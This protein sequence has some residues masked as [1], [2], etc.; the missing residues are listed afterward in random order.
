[1]RRAFLDYRFMLSVALAALVSGMGLSVWPLPIDHPIL[2]LIALNRPAI[3]QGVSYTYAAMWF[4]TPFLV[5]NVV[6]SVA[7]IFFVAR[8]PAM[9]PSAL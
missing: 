8:V 2:G 9:G 7:Y 4:T 1:M 3:Y 6:A 5:I